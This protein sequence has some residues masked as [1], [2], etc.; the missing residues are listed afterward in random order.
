MITASKW[1]YMSGAGRWQ[2]RSKYKC[3]G[4]LWVA[5]IQEHQGVQDSSVGH[6][7]AL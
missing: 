4:S 1:V 3:T 6:P 7:S 5:A 2:A